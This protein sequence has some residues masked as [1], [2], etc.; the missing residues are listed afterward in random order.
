[1]F[2]RACCV[3]RPTLPGALESGRADV[4]VLVNVNACVCVCVFVFVFV[5]MLMC[6]VHVHVHVCT[7]G[8]CVRA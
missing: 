4:S 5:C 8:V 2:I 7:H 6:H 3:L 1:M